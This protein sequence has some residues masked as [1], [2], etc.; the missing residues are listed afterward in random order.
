[1]ENC[2]MLDKSTE[3]DGYGGYRTVWSNGVQFKAAIVFRLTS[4]S[5]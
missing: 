2:I 5:K 1:M 3:A 4:S